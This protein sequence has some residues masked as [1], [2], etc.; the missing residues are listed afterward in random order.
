MTTPDEPQSFDPNTPD[1]AR[2]RFAMLT[3]L[4]FVAAAMV[5]AG[6]LLL[7]GNIAAIPSEVGIPLGIALMGIGIVDLLVIV[8]ML[9]KR[10]R[11]T[12]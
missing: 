11:S 9:V 5:V 10:W 3:V 1:P 12:P 4:R 7:S 6:A 2:A 8:P